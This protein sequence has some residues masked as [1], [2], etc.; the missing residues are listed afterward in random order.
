MGTDPPLKRGGYKIRA[1]HLLQRRVQLN[2]GRTPPP[3]KQRHRP[4]RN[5]QEQMNKESLVFI[6]KQKRQQ[7]QQQNKKKSEK[8]KHTI[9][10]TSGNVKCRLFTVLLTFSLKTIQFLCPSS[11][12]ITSSDL[13]RKER[14]IML[15]LLHSVYC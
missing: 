11:H 8:K 2:G 10:S 14:I 6:F 7:Q 15:L 3:R 4:P 5:V 1:L 9:V 13:S 12:L